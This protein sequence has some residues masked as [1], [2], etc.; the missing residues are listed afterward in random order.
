MSVRNSFIVV[1]NNDAEIVTLHEWVATLNRYE[2]ELFRQAD[3]RQVK[4]RQNAIDRGDL[5]LD[6]TTNEYV[7]RDKETANKGKP[8]DRVWLEFWNRY[9]DQCNLVTG[10]RF[11]KEE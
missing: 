7:W 3:I 1:S 4:H 2:Q 10:T 6:S 5:V 11:N 8:T 9:V